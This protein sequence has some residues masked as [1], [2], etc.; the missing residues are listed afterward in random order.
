VPSMQMT[1]EID[2]TRGSP[3]SDSALPVIRDNA[4]ESGPAIGGI[5]QEAVTL[6]GS[7]QEIFGAIWR[8]VALLLRLGDYCRGL[9]RRRFRG[10][11]GRAAR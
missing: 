5:L 4:S 6:A 1:S 10:L 7:W 8:S 2:T 11:A 3:L 9:R